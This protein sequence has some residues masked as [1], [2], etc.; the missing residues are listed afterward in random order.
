MYRLSGKPFKNHSF[1][2]ILLSG[3]Y[4]EFNTRDVVEISNFC[5]DLHWIGESE[6]LGLPVSHIT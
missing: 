3:K 2:G 4:R 5:A 6:A 1:L